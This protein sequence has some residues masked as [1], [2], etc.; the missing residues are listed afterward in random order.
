M[1]E[2]QHMSN[3]KAVKAVNG[4]IVLEVYA[5]GSK[6]DG[7]RDKGAPVETK[8]LTPEEALE[9]AEAVVCI[10]S[11]MENLKDVKVMMDVV[12]DIMAKC[13]EAKTQRLK[14]NKDPDAHEL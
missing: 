11:R 4:N 3:I 1:A 12:K 7:V 2:S 10:A 14:K 13:E 6:K 5:S 8:V 9:R